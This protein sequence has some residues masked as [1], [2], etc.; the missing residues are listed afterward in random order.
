MNLSVIVARHHAEMATLIACIEQ[1]DDEIEA[2]Q[3]DLALSEL[4]RE[5]AE[6]DRDHAQRH[7]DDLNDQLARLCSV[8]IQEQT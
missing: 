5:E 2:L 8:F 1:R 3:A 7:A 4:L 6:A